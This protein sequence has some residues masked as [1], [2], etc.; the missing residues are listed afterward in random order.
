[1]VLSAIA[2]VRILLKNFAIGVLRCGLKWTSIRGL[3][4]TAR[5]SAHHPELATL[6]PGILYVV[7][8]IDYQKWAFLTCPCGCAESIMLS[9]SKKRRPHWQVDVDW[10]NRPTVRPSI[11]QTEGCYSHFWIKKGTIHWTP[12][13]GRPHRSRVSKEK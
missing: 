10:L 1:M 9:L 6:K 12:D 3:Q 13:S 4:F 5:M 8:G 2:K 7:G 11:W